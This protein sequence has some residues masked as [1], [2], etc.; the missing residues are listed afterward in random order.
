MSTITP[1][2]GLTLPEGNDNADIS[3]LNENF[4]I[5]DQVLEH[6][7]EDHI[8]DSEAHPNIQILISNLESRLG[9]MELKYQTDVTANP[10]DI[11]FKTLN[12]LLVTGVW[13]EAYA[14]IE[15]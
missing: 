1:N 14:R 6:G 12:G 8:I 10:F 4:L 9:A 7:L 13:N 15:F 3:V 2:Y 11:R 5:L